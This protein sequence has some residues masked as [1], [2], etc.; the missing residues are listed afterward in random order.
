MKNLSAA[1]TAELMKLRRSRVP[2]ITLVFFLFIPM[3]MGLMLFIANH[4]DLA[5]KLGLVGA[6][7][8][9]FGTSDCAGYFAVLNQS[10]AGLGFLGFGFVSAWVFGRE[11]TDRT[12]KDI[13]ALPVS[14]SSIVTAKF[15][16]IFCW[17]TLLTV[18]FFLMALAAGGLFGMGSCPADVLTH[19]AG[20]Y[21]ATAFLTL[22]L[23]TPVAFLAGY[24]RGIVAPIGFVIITLILA[25]FVAII[26]LG[27]YFPW[28]IPGAFTAPPETAGLSIAPVSYVILFLTGLA[29]FWG[30]LAWWRRA[31]HK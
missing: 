21:F 8:S 9:L 17:C 19:A 10:V 6:K 3:M 20:K 18:V 14:R 16:V 28:S 1:L 12:L 30:T 22:I 31:D 11:Y 23:T 4:P 26:G 7:A 29:G 5:A 13:L 27:P 24:G 25:Q 15:L 2:L